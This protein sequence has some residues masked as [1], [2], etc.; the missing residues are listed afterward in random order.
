MLKSP[1]E[2]RL[3]ELKNSLL[4]RYYTWRDR[5]DRSTEAGKKLFCIAK[6]DAYKDAAESLEIDPF[7]GEHKEEEYVGDWFLDAVI[8]G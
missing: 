2:K 4:E 7:I 3:E 6:R 5:A 8:I 1:E